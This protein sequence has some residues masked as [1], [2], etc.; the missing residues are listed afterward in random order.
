MARADRVATGDWIHKAPADWPTQRYLLYAWIE[1][2]H[3][4]LVESLQEHDR[5]RARVRR[6]EA[7]RNRVIGISIGAGAVGSLAYKALLWIGRHL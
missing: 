6:L 1:D 3:A 5:L 4:E 7:F 2:L